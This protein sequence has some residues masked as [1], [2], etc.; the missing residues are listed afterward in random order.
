MSL[1]FISSNNPSSKVGVGLSTIVGPTGPQGIIG[2]TGS[3]GNPGFST[4]TGATGPA[5][6][7]F[8]IHSFSTGAFLTA[9]STQSA[10]AHADI[11]YANNRL[12]VASEL[13]V[14]FPQITG[15]TAH[16]FVYNSFGYQTYSFMPLSGTNAIQTFTTDSLVNEVIIEAWG[17]GGG[18]GYGG[19]GGY[20]KTTISGLSGPHT[21]KLWVGDTG[22][23]GRT[24]GQTFVSTIILAS[25]PARYYDYFQDVVKT[26]YNSSLAFFITGSAGNETYN[27]G[28]VNGTGFIGISPIS[29]PTVIGDQIIEWNAISPIQGSL[30]GTII[31]TG[32]YLYG[33]YTKLFMQTEQISIWGAT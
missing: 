4:N 33:G 9:A 6:P 18:G 21:F 25:G 1:Q 26:G 22:E 24:A 28:T 5:G 17:G 11:Y 29:N 30:T 23:G 31:A 12:N 3:Q 2:P 10:D 20:S 19:N 15:A 7:S 14:N 27:I 32:P 8:T 13:E 16:Q